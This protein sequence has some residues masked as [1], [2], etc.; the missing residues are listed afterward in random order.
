M[1][2]YTYTCT[3]RYQPKCWT[4]VNFRLLLGLALYCH[5]FHVGVRLCWCEQVYLYV[6]VLSLKNLLMIK[7]YSTPEY[8]LEV[9]VLLASIKMDI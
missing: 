3:S 9:I 6:I 2:L 1:A 7:S 5:L 4:S 8:Y